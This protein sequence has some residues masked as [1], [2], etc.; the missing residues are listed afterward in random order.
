LEKLGFLNV[1]GC[2]IN[3]TAVHI[4]RKRGF[5]IDCCPANKLP[6]TDEAFDLIYTAALLIHIPEEESGDVQREIARV[7]KK[8][9]YGYEYYSAE[10]TSRASFIGGLYPQGVP[11]FTFKAPFSDRYLANVPDL[12]FSKRIR[13]EHQDGTGNCDEAFLLEKL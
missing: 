12:K 8:W 11:D 2:D 3:D 13:V 7:S 9:I 10:W 4:C 6:Y 1:Y 5:P